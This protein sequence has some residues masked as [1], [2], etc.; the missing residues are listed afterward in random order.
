MSPAEFVAQFGGT[1]ENVAY[2]FRTLAKCDCARVCGERLRRGAVEHFYE[3][4]RRALF[5]EEEFS[6][7][8][9]SVKSGFSASILSTFMDRAGESLM[10]NKLDS[11]ETRHLTW[12]PLTLDE[13]GFEAVMARMEELYRWLPVEQM[14]AKERMK[15]SG[16][17][18]LN[19]TVA[20]FGF[21]SPM[22]ERDHELPLEG[23]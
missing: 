20:L 9:A 22:P 15:A 3:S 1:I 14:A 21:E 7:F 18:P 19:A 12:Q 23:A 2:H 10:T 13:E 16:E 8:P 4:T 5:S 11:H 17:A 6:A